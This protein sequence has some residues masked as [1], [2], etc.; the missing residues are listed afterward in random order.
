[1]SRGYIRFSAEQSQAL[2]GLWKSYDGI[3]RCNLLPTAAGDILLAT[4]NNLTG[5]C[6]L[7][8]EFQISHKATWGYKWL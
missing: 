6:R 8:P 7:P 4:R 1:M 3:S 2:S 5:D